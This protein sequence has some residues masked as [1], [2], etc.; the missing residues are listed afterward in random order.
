[1]DGVPPTGWLRVG[2]RFW[3]MVTK[4]DDLLKYRKTRRKVVLPVEVVV[5]LLIAMFQT[6]HI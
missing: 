6:F 2:L 4:T 1:M 5:M 3:S